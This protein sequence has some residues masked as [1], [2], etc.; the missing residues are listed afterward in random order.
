MMFQPN[1]LSKSFSTIKAYFKQLREKHII[2]SAFYDHM[3]HFLKNEGMQA[4]SLN[5]FMNYFMHVCV[6]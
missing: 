1:D 2:N 6:C 4:S 5:T 3:K